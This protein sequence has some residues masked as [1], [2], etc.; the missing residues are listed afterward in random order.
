MD[1]EVNTADY[2]N[3]RVLVL[4]A[5]PDQQSSRNIRVT[6]MQ[7]ADSIY[8]DDFGMGIQ[9]LTLSG[10]TAWRSAQGKWNGQPIDGE[11]AARHLQYD[12]IDWYFSMEQAGPSP[13]GMVMAI[14]DHAFGRAWTV[15]PIGNVQFAITSQSPVTRNF[16]VQ[17]LVLSDL[18]NGV[19]VTP[20]IDPVVQ[21]L[22]NPKQVQKYTHSNVKSVQKKSVA[23]SQKKPFI[24]TVQSG[25]TLWT[26][27]KRFLS[28]QA[29]NTQISSF[30]RRIVDTN[31]IANPNLIFVGQ[32]LTIPR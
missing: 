17:F 27:S 31:H 1:I 12:I 28:I 14:Y 7:T 22:Q 4:P 6:V 21:V 20:V 11:T 8:T 25:D 18:A 19:S 23:H 26:I 15:K 9:T 30:V 5:N 29:T 16:S 3:P 32:R 13:Q 24:Y 10:T 2:S